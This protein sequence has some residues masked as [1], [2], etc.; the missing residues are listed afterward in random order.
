VLSERNA[1]PIF[2][3]IALLQLARVRLFQ[4]ADAEGLPLAD[5]LIEASERIAAERNNTLGHVQ[6][7][8]VAEYRGDFVA[9][10]DIAL[11][12]LDQAQRLK[13]RVSVVACHAFLARLATRQGDRQRAQT[14]LATGLPLA[15]ELE[16]RSLIADLLRIRAQACWA[17]GDRD[18]ARAA[19]TECLALIQTSD[20][21][22]RLIEWLA[23]AENH[24]ALIGM[25]RSPADR[26][27]HEV[28]LAE[29]PA[30]KPTYRTTPPFADALAA[31]ST[32]LAGTPLEDSDT[33]IIACG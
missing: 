27:W 8:M 1:I 7:G 4:G 25:P 12:A 13:D 16:D 3:C 5:Q 14:W 26:L 17:A 21:Q 2:R 31:A 9:A 6:R 15:R 24:R 30:V 19:A 11:A 18:D 22:R 29:L 33:G 28:L 20:H 23:A 10:T 32:W